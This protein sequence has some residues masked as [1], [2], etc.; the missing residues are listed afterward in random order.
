MCLTPLQLLAKKPIGGMVVPEILRTVT[1]AADHKNSFIV[2]FF[3]CWSPDQQQKIM[4]YS[5]HSIFSVTFLRKKVTKKPPEI[6][7]AMISVLCL[8]VAVALLW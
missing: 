8:D 5:F 7:Y 3:R 1:A 2:I 4:Y 6:N